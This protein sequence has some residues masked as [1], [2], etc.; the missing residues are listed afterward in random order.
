M[1]S[2]VSCLFFL[3]IIFNKSSIKKENKQKL[4]IV[5]NIC[6]RECKMWVAG[7]WTGCLFGFGRFLNIIYELVSA[8]RQKSGMALLIILFYIFIYNCTWCR[9]LPFRLP[10]SLVWECISM[11]YV[12]LYM[13]NTAI[14]FDMVHHL[15]QGHFHQIKL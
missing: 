6:Q 10:K 14:T 8:P 12:L 7:N 4:L 11:L 1:F 15:Y 5:V 9:L 3:K 13:L 2:F